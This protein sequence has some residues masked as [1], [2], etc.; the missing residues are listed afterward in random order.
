MYKPKGH[1]QPQKNL[2]ATID[3]TATNPTVMKIFS[4]PD[5]E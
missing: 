3:M 5:V 2:P 4:K 1:S